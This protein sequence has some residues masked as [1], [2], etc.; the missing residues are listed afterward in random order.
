M[1]AFSPSLLLHTER[2]AG[3]AMLLINKMAV[4]FQAQTRLDSN[5][6]RPLDR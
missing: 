3:L 1:F 4:I 6:F 2:L 5:D